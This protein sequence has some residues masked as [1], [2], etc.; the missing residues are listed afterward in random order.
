M[1]QISNHVEDYSEQL[2]RLYHNEIH[3]YSDNDFGNMC[4]NITFQVTEDCCMRCTY[5]YQHT[6]VSNHRMSFDV[7]KQFIDDLL[8]KSR[9]V[10]CYIPDDTIG[11]I[12]EFIGG[13]PLME[14]D[15]I[16]RIVDYFIEKCIQFKHPW[17]TR[18]RIAMSSNG[19]LYFQPKVQEFIKK[20]INH[21][22]YSVSIDGCKELHDLC[23]LDMEGKGTYDR[24][25]AALDYHNKVYNGGMPSK[26]TI[27]PDNINYLSKAIISMI[28]HGFK[29]I[30]FNPVFEEG[31]D[32]DHARTYY[33]ELKIVSDYIISHNLF[34]PNNLILPTLSTNYCHPMDPSDDRNYC[35]GVGG[36]LAID[37]QGNIYP[38]I[39]YMPNALNGKQEPYVIGNVKEGIMQ[40]HETI[41][42]VDCLKCITRKSQSTD[43][44]FDCPIASGCAWCSGY[45]YE[46]FG[47]ANKRTTF[48]CDLHKARSL[49]IYYLWNS[50]YRSIESKDRLK[51]SLPKD[52][53][54]QIITEDEYNMLMSI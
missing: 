23:R 11:V 44:C 29:E 47:D 42:K 2:N 1:N 14:I 19:L 17:A 12:L 43:E 30:Y 15:L 7:A 51:L 54:L 46:Y 8:T 27:S 6:K 22:S 48:I 49:G 9:K 25:I 26:M 18:F 32:L 34:D 36:M 37:W 28:E 38:C 33:K 24:A 10:S 53:A 31:W 4:R 16:D 40:T 35:G 39:R 3:H 52:W 20:H 13:E 50:W 21:L 5:C 45:N 41:D